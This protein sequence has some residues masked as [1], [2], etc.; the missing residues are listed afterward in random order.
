MHGVPEIQAL[1]G[2]GLSF[3]KILGDI[4][5]ISMHFGNSG[6]SWIGMGRSF[7]HTSGHGPAIEA[8]VCIRSTPHQIMPPALAENSQDKPRNIGYLLSSERNRSP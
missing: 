4:W 1:S 7:R 5:G 2:C 3:Q 8:T 6:G